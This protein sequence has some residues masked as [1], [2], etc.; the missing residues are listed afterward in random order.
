VTPVQTILDAL[1][2]AIG[3]NNKCRLTWDRSGA[4]TF[5]LLAG[6]RSQWTVE[7]IYGRVGQF[8]L[9]CDSMVVTNPTLRYEVIGEQIKLDASCLVPSSVLGIN[10]K[11]GASEPVGISP[12]MVFSLLSMVWSLLHPRLTLNLPGTIELV[13]SMPSQDQL[14]I[15]FVKAPTVTAVF[16]VQFEC[17]PN[18]MTLTEHYTK[19]LYKAG[20]F[21]REQTWS[22]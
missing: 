13:M 22:F 14:D 16:G 19:V 18:Q 6:D 1:S 9:R 17:V 15:W 2:R 5:N 12:M 11:V 8:S 10:S 20:W 21:S 7:N 4:A 3:I